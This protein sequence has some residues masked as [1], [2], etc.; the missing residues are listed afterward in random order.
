MHVIRTLLLSIAWLAAALLIA[1]GGAGIIAA[2]NHLPGT[3]ARPE[4]TWT[5]DR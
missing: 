5:G 2:G 1:V 3:S 4:L